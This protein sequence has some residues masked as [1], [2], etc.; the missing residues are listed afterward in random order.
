MINNFKY[1]LIQ[2][3]NGEEHVCQLYKNMDD[4]STELNIHRT[5]IYN[6]YYE[7]EKYYKIIKNQT[8]YL[9]KKI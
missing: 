9:I 6:N 8:E 1:I 3:Y 5:T 2:L 7:N 4:I